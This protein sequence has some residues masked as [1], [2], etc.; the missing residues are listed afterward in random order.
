VSPIKID[1]MISPKEIEPKKLDGRI[2]V[3]IDLLRAT[4]TVA[5]AVFNGCSRIY[6][7]ETVEEAFNLKQAM[8]PKLPL[9]GG[10]RKG[11]K[12]EGFDLGNSPLEFAGD[13]VGGRDL[14]FTTT[15]GT[16]AIKAAKG[17]AKLLTCSLVNLGSVA[18]YISSMPDDMVVICAG[19][20]GQF[21]LEDAACAGRL[22]LRLL[23]HGSSDIR[24][25]DGAKAARVIA[26]AYP[27]FSEVMAVSEHGA[28]LKE[29]GLGRD[30][31]F[32]AQEDKFDLVVGYREG[33]LIK[34]Q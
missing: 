16:R 23:E 10:E 14:I 19:R 20:G 31:E 2:A 7:V 17:A 32:C 13:I 22:I 9:L 5:T 3:V 26:G 6:P 34:I 8:Y 4:S 28:Y 11:L 21:S 24:L 1:V 15:N 27:D 25:D 18:R 12:V 29:I 33:F 30:L